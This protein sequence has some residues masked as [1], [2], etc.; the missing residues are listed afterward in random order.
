[1]CH[2]M[3]MLPVLGLMVFRLWPMSIAAPVY[4]IILVVSLAVYYLIVQA[5]H[6]PVMTGREEILRKTGTVVE[7]RERRIQVRVRGEIWNAESSDR[8]RIGDTVSIAGIDGLVLQV[9]RSES[10]AAGIAS[11]F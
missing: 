1:M 3:L 11:P 8:L 5:M 7:V 9:R 10:T 4:I 6:R 2:L